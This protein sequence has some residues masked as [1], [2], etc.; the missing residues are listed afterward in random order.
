M[1]SETAAPGSIDMIHSTSSLNPISLFVSLVGM[2]RASVLGVGIAIGL[3]KKRNERQTTE[4]SRQPKSWIDIH[5]GGDRATDGR[6]PGIRPAQL[7]CTRLL[8]MVAGMCP[9]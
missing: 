6:L 2:E 5:S 9:N 1:P 8:A 3:G 7:I 4:F